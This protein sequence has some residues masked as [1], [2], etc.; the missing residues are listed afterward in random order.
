V[1]VWCLL[2][3][4]GIFALCQALRDL[5]RRT[6]RAVGK[7]RKGEA[8]CALGTPSPLPELPGLSHA[9]WEGCGEPTRSEFSTCFPLPRHFPLCN[10]WHKTVQD[11]A[12]A[13]WLEKEAEAV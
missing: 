1:F 12:F 8:G 13:S 9:L 2:G 4:G 7:R 5:C 6:S 3:T 11:Q 10:V